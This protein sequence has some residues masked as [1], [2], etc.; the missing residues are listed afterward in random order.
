ME[1]FFA[2]VFGITQL[3]GFIVH[4]LT[5]GSGLAALIF[6]LVWWTWQQFTWALDTAHTTLAGFEIR[7]MVA[8]AA[9][10]FRAVSISDASMAAHSNPAS[11]WSRTWAAWT[12][13]E[14]THSRSKPIRPRS[15]AAA[16][17]S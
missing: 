17:C 4:G 10:F 8:T 11:P 7:A 16:S 5:G 9:A 2:L 12:N 13:A 3:A 15:V 6:W 1:L 14:R